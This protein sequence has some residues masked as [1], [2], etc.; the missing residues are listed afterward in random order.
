MEQFNYDVHG[1]IR[2]NSNVD[3]SQVNRRL[4]YFKVEKTDPNIVVRLARDFKID[5]NKAIRLTPNFFGVK[6]GKWIYYDKSLVHFKLKLLIRNILDKTEIMATYP[7]L[8]MHVRLGR[9][10][11]L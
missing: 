7:Y 9:I 10:T 11:P 2:I 5:R 4:K 6:N 3:L 1:L 8:K